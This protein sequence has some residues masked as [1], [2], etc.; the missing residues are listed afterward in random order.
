ML[1][2]K[3][4]EK[5]KT[6]YV[7]KLFFFEKSA[8]YEI[9]WKNIVE[10]GRP[11]MTIWRMPIARWIP[12]DT[13]TFPEYITLILHYNNGCNHA[14]QCYVLLIH[15]SPVLLFLDQRQISWTGIAQSV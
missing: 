11:Q 1:Q 12:K 8:V 2:T 4:V 13:D 7:Q 14:P 5:V 6:F 10:R 15:T 9:I 3:V